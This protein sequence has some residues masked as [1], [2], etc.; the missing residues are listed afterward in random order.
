MARPAIAVTDSVF[1][2]HDLGKAALARLN[3][4]DRRPRE[5]ASPSITCRDYCI[6]EV[7][8][9]TLALLLSSIRKLIVS[10]HTAKSL[11]PISA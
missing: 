6:R 5:K 2:T 10:L 3:P 8:D 11:D 1:P 7:S 4:T 9:H